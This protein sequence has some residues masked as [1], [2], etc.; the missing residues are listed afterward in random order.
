[1]AGSRRS[2]SRKLVSPITRA[3]GTWSR[4]SRMACTPSTRGITRSISTTSG[5]RRCAA[6][7]ASRP[8]PASP[9]TSMP[10][11]SDRN[12]RS[13]SRTTAW[14]S[15]TSTRIASST[16][17]LQPH[18]RAP[19]RRRR[20]GEAAAQALRPLLHRGQPEPPRAYLGR[21]GI[22]AGAVVA[23]LEHHAPI[24]VREPQADV[25]GVRVAHRVAQRL[26]GDAKDLA[27]AARVGLDDGLEVELDLPGLEGAHDVDVLAQ[28]PA[29]AVALEVG[30]A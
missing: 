15:T 28:R 11:W 10:S 7:I 25:V 22:E 1:M 6:A 23:H 13:P 14:S 3:P 27:R 19:A 30:R 4:S 8:S 9:T 12:V 24:L 5:R 29:Q 20:D 17:R 18:R 21:V 26:L 2:S 16:R